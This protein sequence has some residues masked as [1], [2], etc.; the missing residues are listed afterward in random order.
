VFCYANTQCIEYSPIK[1]YKAC[2]PEKPHQEQQDINKFEWRFC[3]NYIPLNS[4]T[5]IIACPIPWCDLVINEEFGMGK[6]HWLFNA[7][8]GYH[9]LAVAFLTTTNN[10]TLTINSNYNSVV[11]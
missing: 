2:L 10:F 11:L 9:Q 8:M 3:V 7:S 5:R 6:F 4:V 1:R